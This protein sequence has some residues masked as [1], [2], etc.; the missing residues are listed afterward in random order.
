MQE[1]S[2][3]MQKVAFVYLQKAYLSIRMRSVTSCK[4]LTVA[5]RQVVIVTKT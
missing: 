2:D 3:K 4:S 5:L 1:S